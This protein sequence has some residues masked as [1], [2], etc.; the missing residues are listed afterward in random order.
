MYVIGAPQVSPITQ[1]TQELQSNY[2]HERENDKDYEHVFLQMFDYPLISGTPSSWSLPHSQSSPSNFQSINVD[3][4]TQTSQIQE[5]DWLRKV[6]YIP[7]CRIEEPLTGH[8][9]FK[10][11]ILQ[12]T[13]TMKKVVLSTTEPSLILLVT[14]GSIE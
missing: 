6:G 13:W 12:Q 5:F 7:I 1:I 14:D 10:N 11:T 3:A 8:K 9:L 4:Q 2:N